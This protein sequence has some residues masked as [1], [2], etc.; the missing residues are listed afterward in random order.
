MV[1]TKRLIYG[2]VLVGASLLSCFA[3]CDI[4]GLPTAADDSTTLYQICFSYYMNQNF[5]DTVSFSYVDCYTYTTYDYG[6]TNAQD[7]RIIRFHS[8]GTNEFRT[9]LL[10][11]PGWRIFTTDGW[12]GNYDPIHGITK[13]TMTIVTMTTSALT[14]PTVNVCFGDYYDES[15]GMMEG[16]NG[17]YEITN[18]TST[19]NPGGGPF[20][21][22]YVFTPKDVDRHY[23]AITPIYETYIVCFSCYYTCI[24]NDP[25]AA[26]TSVPATTDGGKVTATPG[27]NPFNL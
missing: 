15:T 16:R 19:T 12:W 11:I 22:D 18:L 7:Q 10:N 17:D 21:I 24:N 14:T 4:K 25:A 26:T 13:V 6:L 9:D 23:F 5:P 1:K 20:L 3:F 27:S 2:S 8:K